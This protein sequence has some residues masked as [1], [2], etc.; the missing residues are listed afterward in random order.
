MKEG[1][2]KRFGAVRVPGRILKG[3]S[4][5]GDGFPFKGEID[6]MP[7]FSVV[8]SEAKDTSLH[9]V[10]PTKV[11]GRDFEVANVIHSGEYSDLYGAVNIK[12]N[13]VQNVH[14]ERN[15]S[16]TLGYRLIGM[17]FQDDE[18]RVLK[19][20]DLLRRNGIETEKIEQVIEPAEV[21]VNGE[22][23]SITELKKRIIDYAKQCVS[24]GVI[25]LSM[26]RYS[27]HPIPFT[28][29]EISLIEKDLEL[30]RFL[31]LVRSF[32]VT[33]RIMDLAQTKT[34]EEFEE[35]M[36]KVFKF[37][38]TREGLEA[39]REG[40]EAQYFD[41]QNPQ[42][43]DRFFRDF[44][45]SR[46]AKNLAR[47]HNLGLAH[48]FPTVH[49]FSLVGSIY[50]L[51]TVTGKVLFDS[52]EP[53]GSSEIR[54][55]LNIATESFVSYLRMTPEDED[56]I[57]DKNTHF[58]FKEQI[59]EKVF[60]DFLRTFYLEYLRSRNLP[61]LNIDYNQFEN[62]WITKEVAKQRQKIKSPDGSVEELTASFREDMGTGDL[63]EVL[64]QDLKSVIK[65]KIKVFQPNS[66]VSIHDE[67]EI[68]VRD[69][70]D[71]YAGEFAD[72]VVVQLLSGVKRKT[73]VEILEIIIKRLKG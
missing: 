49:N 14:L 13:N 47:I 67:F 48:H 28:L 65:D 68:E 59:G 44:L 58:Y 52:D 66:E 39:K 62:S 27:A 2:Y 8:S 51:D 54:E 36:S 22:R 72:E 16:N 71:H 26:S 60:I 50:D 64:V 69:A 73:S 19:A 45:P 7:T 15:N 32:Q 4:T 30:K 57:A 25:P 61:E 17:F 1:L 38:N 21:I 31:F 46:C 23:I 12:G 53:V 5:K 56:Q 11:H 34:K 20:S 41:V 18:E 70:V 24:V 63:A 6:D 43:V 35:M 29:D 9:L 55:D 40:R 37:I 33:E 3:K 10:K 42:D